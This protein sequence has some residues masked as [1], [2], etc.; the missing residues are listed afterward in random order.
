MTGS[1]WGDNNTKVGRTNLVTALLWISGN[2]HPW[3][4]TQDQDVWERGVPFRRRAAPRSGTHMEF[5][6]FWVL[7]FYVLVETR[8]RDLLTA[9]GSPFFS[10]SLCCHRQYYGVGCIIHAEGLL[11]C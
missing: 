5:P 4:T 8:I 10:A 9:I 6:G 2:V 7:L 3:D 11:G 1:G